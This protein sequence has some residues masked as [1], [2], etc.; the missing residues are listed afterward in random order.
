MV[1]TYQ[2]RNE[3]ALVIHGAPPAP[4]PP[5]FFEQP[6]LPTSVALDARRRRDDTGARVARISAMVGARLGRRA[7]ICPSAQVEENF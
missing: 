1:R 6:A 5:L 7:H 2:V 4:G 3:R